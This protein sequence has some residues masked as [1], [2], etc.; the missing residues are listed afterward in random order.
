M[1]KILVPTDFSL[2][3]NYALENASFFAKLNKGSLTVVHIVIDKKKIDQEAIDQKFELL[4]KQPYLKEV[5]ANFV[6]VEG[7]NISKAINKIGVELGVDL[8]VMGS[9]GANNTGEII[10]G[11]T[12]ENV[13][14]RSEINVLAI[15]REI[16]S[17]DLNRI[18]FPSDF[19]KEANSIF[20]TVK[21]YAKAF[22]ASI[23]LLS[24]NKSDKEVLTKKAKAKMDD[25]IQF[26]QL[27]EEGIVY[28]KSISTNSSAEFGILNYSIDNSIDMIAIGTHG[29]GVLKK[30]LQESTSQSLVR[31][32][33]KPV[34]TMRFK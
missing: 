13:I 20:E 22:N 12:T 7:G 5:N 4:K 11:S 32:A 14:R 15:K 6:V 9:N 8:I 28:R 18:L 23:H 24:V 25:F 16:I 27:N 21:D 3:A 10:L 17:F 2:H 31:D 29:R 33:F 1:N 19:S 34:L 26:R 30:L